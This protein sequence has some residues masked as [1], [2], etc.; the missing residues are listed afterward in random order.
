MSLQS[1]AW[2]HCLNWARKTRNSMS[3]LGIVTSYGSEPEFFSDTRPVPSQIRSDFLYSKA[4]SSIGTLKKLVSLAS[5]LDHK[6][7]VPGT[8]DVYFRTSFSTIRH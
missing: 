7:D 3:T 6:I 1:I 4:L 2:T 5:S 8:Y